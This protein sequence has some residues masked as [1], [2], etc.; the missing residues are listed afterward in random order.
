[1][2]GSDRVK[3]ASSGVKLTYDDFLKFPDDGKRHEIIDGEHYVTPSPNTRH[4]DLVVRLCLA[5]GNFLRENPGHGRVFV[6]PF[7]VVFSFHD[8]VEPDLLL[9]AADQLDI[10]TGKISI[11]VIK[12]YRLNND[13]LDPTHDGQTVISAALAR[14]EELD[15]P[16]IHNDALQFALEAIEKHLPNLPSK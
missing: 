3:P 12:N 4:Q 1:M 8:I 13:Y 9:V 2:P 6:A 11:T 16:P 14:M 15:I 7:D 10:L 5:V